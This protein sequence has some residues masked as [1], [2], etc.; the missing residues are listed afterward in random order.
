MSVL[1]GLIVSY[2]ACK[3]VF[4]K[5]Q[6]VTQRGDPWNR[7]QR[8]YK[9]NG[10]ICLVVMFAPRVSVTKMSQLA[11]FLYFLLIPATIW[12]KYLMH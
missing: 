9:K 8:F 12:A 11:H 2:L 7:A 1:T 5:P 6:H 4:Y 3:C 10:I